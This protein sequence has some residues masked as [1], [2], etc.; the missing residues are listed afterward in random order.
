MKILFLNSPAFAKKDMLEAF[1]NC[2]IETGLFMHEDYNVRQ[3]AAFDA[4]FDAAV[5]NT[6]YSFVFSFNYYPI[7]A[8]CAHRHNLPYVSYIY[9]S[10]LVALYSFT[11]TYPTNYIFLFDYPIYQELKQG[12][13]DRVFYLPLAANARRLSS[14]QAD[15][16]IADKV[17][18]EISFVGSLYNEDHPL[19]ERLYKNLPAFTQGYLDAILAA[20]QQIYG[21]FLIPDLL[22]NSILT[23]MQK[24]VPYTPNADGIETPRYI[25][26]NY[27]LARK[28][29]E[30]D[31]TAILKKLSSSHQLKLY[32]Y[33]PTPQLPDVENMGVIDYYEIMPLVFQHSKINLNITLRSIQKG[34][35]L[36]AFDIMGSG[37]FLLTNYQEDFLTYFVPGEDFIYYSSYDEAET[38]ASY[39]L[40]HEKER[41][42]IAANALGKI[43]DSHTFEHRIHTMLSILCDE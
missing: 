33:N 1:H 31:R 42:Q 7:L 40:S 20:Q 30:L 13:I 9:D 26:A 12:G 28:L 43:L 14:M 29:A 18:S 32:T 23:D 38:Y 22:N 10:P 3:S 35:P 37:G 27:F 25:Y 34:I 16:S 5:E 4:A 2:E 39:Y 17:A 8:S 24:S 6:S 19:Y 15:N 11:I 41:Q 21:E 36:R